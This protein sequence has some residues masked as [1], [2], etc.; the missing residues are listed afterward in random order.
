MLMHAALLTQPL[1][2]HMVRENAAQC[3]MI[4]E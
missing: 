3:Y 2:I 1:G 4:V